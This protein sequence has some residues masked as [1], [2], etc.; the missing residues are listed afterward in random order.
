MLLTVLLLALSACLVCAMSDGIKNNYG[1]M[2][3]AIMENTGATY[4]SVSF[5]LALGQL[6]YGLFQPV[7][8]VLAQKKGGTRTLILGVCLMLAGLVLLPHCRSPLSLTL[9]LGIL[10][11]A[12][13]GATSYGILIGTVTPKIPQSTVSLVSGVVNASSGVG[14]ALLSPVI[15]ML[16]A[17]G[18]I[19]AAM[20]VLSVPTLLLVPLCL[21]VGH[22]KSYGDEAGNTMQAAV[23]QD[24]AR[25]ATERETMTLRGVTRRPA[26]AGIAAKALSPFADAFQSRTYRLL[27]AGFFTCGFHMALIS[28]HLP[29]QITSY[30]IGEATASYVFSIYGIL[31]MV[32]SVLSGLLCGKLRMKNVLGTYY[33]L[34]SAGTLVFFALPKTLPVIVG[35]AVLLGMTG[36]A[37]VPPVSGIIG[38]EFGANRVGALYGF[39]FFIHSLGGFLGA[40]LGG[41]CVDVFGGYVQ[42]WA[43]DVVLC[44]VAATVSYLIEN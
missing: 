5:V 11:P 20:M 38:R 17:K 2:L 35:Y 43:V 9:C 40:W 7:F 31:T 32:G 4:A 19:L 23:P 29:S 37:T 13:T 8:G 21:F 22:A 30:G 44:A 18:G 27:M 39:V 24:D 6:L 10:L 25:D 1:I 42:I 28:N 14:N 15:Q 41:L 34:R 33:A 36:A 16:L 3:S 12:G 26:V